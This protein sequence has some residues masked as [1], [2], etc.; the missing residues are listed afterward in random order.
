MFFQRINKQRTWTRKG[1]S[2][3]TWK[4]DQ[5]LIVEIEYFTKVK[6]MEKSST[7]F[8]EMEDLSVIY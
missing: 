2:F 7:L 1:R 4:R 3:I 5:D 6:R 8:S